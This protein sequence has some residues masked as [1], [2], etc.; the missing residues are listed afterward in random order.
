MPLLDI[1]V[2][3]AKI[4]ILMKQSK[5]I[6]ITVVII[7]LIAVSVRLT[8]LIIIKSNP[9]FD[10]PIM[11][12]KYHEEWAQEIATGNLFE[13]SPFYRAPGYPYF[14]GLIYT[15]FGKGY[16][17]PRLIGIIIGALSCALVYLIGKEIFSHKIGVLTGLLACFYG[18]LIYFDSM[19][20]TV[21]LEIFFSLFGIYWL[22]RW[23]KAQKS[24]YILIAAIFWGLVSIVRPNFLIFVPVLAAYILLCYKKLSLIK[25]LKAIAFFIGGILPFLIAVMVINVFVGKDA[26]ILAW[27]GGVNLYFGNN[28]AA[29][30]WSAT[31]PEINATWWGGYRDAIV[32][33]ER[34][35]GHELRPSQVSNYWFKRGF[36]FIF[37][38]P[39]AWAKLMVKKI[40]LFCNSFEISNNQSVEAFREY[41]F[42]MRLPILN[43][44]LILA[45]ATL[46]IILSLKKKRTWLISLFIISYAFS[47]I[48]FFVTARYRMPIVPFLIIFSSY[49][50]YWIIDKIRRR[51]FRNA[52][53]VS[54]IFIVIFTMCNLDLYGSRIV[55]KSLIHVSLGNRYFEKGDFNE[56]IGEYNKALKYNP[57]NVDALNASGNT[58]M[59][60]G[61]RAE[62]TNLY[63]KS[64]SIAPSMDA[65]CKMG[66]IHSMQG[67]VDSA[68]YYFN[69]A[70]ARDSTNP[71]PYYY[72]G[73]HH[74]NY[75]I[76]DKAIYYL[77][78]A[79][80]HYP[81]PQYKRNI[82]YNLGK[83]Y[84]EIGNPDKAKQHLFEA[85]VNYKDVRQILKH[86]Q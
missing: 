85:G 49:T 38:Q 29:N 78:L 53:L 12:E 34:A 33:A 28:P 36:A 82:H 77:E 63:R 52:A 72:L 9:Y 57:K 32:I 4:Y 41:S 80:K 48:I 46:G 13:R 27:N 58:Y 22:I 6:L 73:M 84:F 61:D 75:R 70:I 15:V 25:K 83:L 79:L 74:A 21:Y 54:I 68:Q 55:N 67:A 30:G 86:I 47:I 3:S 45:L 16:F 42:L 56:A 5:K 10:S 7:F 18:M 14:L 20:L 66:I 31:S 40:Y 51:D 11:D 71:E 8:N 23:T 37:S 50:I 44:G 2:F 1:R 39:F 81:E 24:R 62:A 17:I 64:L 69:T 76:H 26:V 65:Q 59:M 60:L 43:Y 35:A 19:L